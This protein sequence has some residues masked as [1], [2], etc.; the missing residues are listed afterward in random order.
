MNPLLKRAAKVAQAMNPPPPP[1][2]KWIDAETWAANPEA[3]KEPGVLYCRWMS[4][5]EAEAV[6]AK[7]EGRAVT[8]D[9]SASST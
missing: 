3:Y 2:V 7:A 8:G 5:A 1:I 9:D 4:R 6:A